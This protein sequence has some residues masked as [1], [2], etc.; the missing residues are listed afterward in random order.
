MSVSYVRAMQASLWIRLSPF[1]FLLLWA[2][3]F[4]F[5]KVGL[6]YADPFTFLTLRY[7]CVVGILIPFVLWIRPKFPTTTQGWAPLIG[8]GL[9]L[10]TG[11]FAFTYLSLRFGLS[12][13]AVALITCQQPI[14]IGLL[15]PKIT[16]ERVTPA[17][18]VGLT[19]G[20][21]GACTV[22]LA[23]S[24]AQATSFWGVLFGVLALLCIT[25]S[26][27]IEKRSSSAT[28][29]VATNFVHY[30]IGLLITAPLAYYLE[31]MRVEWSWQ[32]I[33]S[34]TYLVFGASLLAISLLLAMIRH[35]EASRVTALFFLVPPTTALIAFIFIGESLDLVS[36]PG[37]VLVV[38]GIFVVMRKS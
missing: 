9:F 22:I 32:F 36:L 6:T 20:V 8:V 10:Q 25:C 4:V 29:P 26:V 7:V 17:R 27:F 19:L 34:L 23:N 13:G 38:I 12:A 14:L 18:W 33:V 16:G 28:H 35:G 11:Y 24:S 37:M 30:T 5:L 15:A 2:N 21:I 1:A 3:G 31:P